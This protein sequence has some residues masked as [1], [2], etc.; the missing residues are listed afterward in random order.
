MIR[1]QD[2]KYL[3]IHLIWIHKIVFSLQRNFCLALYL[4]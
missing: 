4:L 1:L 2:A 3:R